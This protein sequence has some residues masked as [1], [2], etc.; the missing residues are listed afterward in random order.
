MVKQDFVQLV[1]DKYSEAVKDGSVQFTE[2]TN[3]KLKDKCSGMPYYVSLAKS[4]I[5]KD[6]ATKDKVDPFESPLESMV[7]NADVNG[8]GK[9]Q[10]LLNKY[11]I[12]EDHLILATKQF[13][14]QDSILTPEE[15]ITAYKI[16]CDLDDEDE[17]KRH[18]M[19][20]NCGPES[21]SSQDHKHLQIVKLPQNFITFQDK[22]C[23]GKEHFLPSIQDEPLQDNKVAFAHFVLPLPEDSDEVNEELLAMSF[24]S[25]LQRTLTFFQDWLN[26]KPNR[27]KS[28]NVL[29]TKNWICLVPRSNANSL[30][31]YINL[32]KDQEIEAKKLA[33]EAKKLAEE[34]AK[35]DA[36]NEN[37]IEEI[38]EE[39]DEEKKEEKEEEKK[40][41][42]EE[43]KEEELDEEPAETIELSLNALGYAGLVLVKDE[44]LMNKIIELPDLVDQALYHCGFPNT[45]GQRPGEY[46][47]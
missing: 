18:L 3:K 22:L 16:I 23:S 10:L 8:D 28:Y 36:E 30:Q 34:Q 35:K 47:Y 4:L 20:F 11:P 6:N 17:N 42:E 46:N 1:H 21:G 43:K 31:G 32:K 27:V 15:L 44:E 41:E 13:A 45:S 25:L 33:E 29:L 2:T 12:V 26:E 9:L 5:A 14:R 40:D 38:A 37:K 19:F 39:K 24:V 7:V